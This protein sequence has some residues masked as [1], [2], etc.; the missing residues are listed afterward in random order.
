MYL[1]HSYSEYLNSKVL[2]LSF[3]YVRRETLCKIV[4]SS[5]CLSGKQRHSSAPQNKP[6]FSRLFMIIVIHVWSVWSLLRNEI[7]VPSLNFGIVGCV[8]FLTYN[9]GKG[10]NPTLLPQP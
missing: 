9:L 1:E 10:M 7:G 3:K 8:H 5:A 2:H 4:I 6:P